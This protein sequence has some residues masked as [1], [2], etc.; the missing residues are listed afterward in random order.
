[1]RTKGDLTLESVAVGSFACNCSLIY[2][3]STREAIIVDPGNDLDQIMKHINDRKLKVKKLLHTHA[4][5]DH[6]GQSAEVA[7]QTGA[8][9]HLHNEDM[10]LYEALSDQGKYFNEPVAESGEIHSHLRDDETFSL[11][12]IE[13]KEFLHTIHT[14]GHTPG[15]CCFYTDHFDTPLLLAGD[16]LFKGSVGRTDLPGGD[17]DQIISSIKSRLI[18][19]PGETEVIT[20]HGPETMIHLEKSSN[21]FLQ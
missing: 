4:H 14:P 21:P 9:L 18:G 7:R 20:G 1:M 12:S 10:F 19:L 15:S 2:S 11:E 3:N 6:I 8:T 13:L 17:G 16:T 5:F